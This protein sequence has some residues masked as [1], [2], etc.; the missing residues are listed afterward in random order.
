MGSPANSAQ[1]GGGSAQSPSQNGQGPGAV[2]LSCQKCWVEVELLDDDSKPV[3]GEAWWIKLP[4]GN[5][6]EGK[7]DANGRVKL[8]GIPCGECIVRFPRC[9]Y[10]AVRWTGEYPPGKTEWIE[11]K[12]V[13]DYGRALGGESWTMVLSDGTTQSGKLDENGFIRVQGIPKGE[14]RVTFPNLEGSDIAQE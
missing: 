7:L 6:R 8:E 1:S 13:D 10:E 3:A 4:D 12:V 9:D 14:V 11:L 2:V 5:V